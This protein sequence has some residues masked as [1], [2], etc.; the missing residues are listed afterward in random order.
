MSGEAILNHPKGAGVFP[1]VDL[2]EPDGHGYLFA[3]AV[4]DRRLP[5]AYFFPRKRG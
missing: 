5:F 1:K 3:A 2:I 4:V